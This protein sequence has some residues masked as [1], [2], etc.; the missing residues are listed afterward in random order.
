MAVQIKEIII[1]GKVG[2]SNQMTDHKLLETINEQ[3]SKKSSGTGLK[4]SEKRQLIEEC[5]YAV[6]KELE[7]KLGY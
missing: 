7:T 5:V 1:Q 2:Q 4:E 6:L 3:V